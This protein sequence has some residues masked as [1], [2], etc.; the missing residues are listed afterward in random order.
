VVHAAVGA[1]FFDREN[2]VGLFDDADRFVIARRAD[3]VEAGIRVGDIA[4]GGALANFF[5]GVSNGVG[6]CHGFFRRGAQEM[7]CETL[8]SFLS[9]AGKMLQSVDKSFNGGGEIRHE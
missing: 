1:R 4:A 8:G 6:E 2:V 7:E 5:F 3:A 9:N